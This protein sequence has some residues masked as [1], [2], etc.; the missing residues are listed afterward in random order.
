MKCFNHPESDA[1]GICKSCQKGICH[2]CAID[3]GKGIACKGQCE[4]DVT[5]VNEALARNMELGSL[6]RNIMQGFPNN[7]MI[8][9]FFFMLMGL[10][11]SAWG[12]FS[13]R[14]SGF[15]VVLGVGFVLY[16]VIQLS[17]ALRLQRRY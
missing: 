17:R 15:I 6:N 9:S 10:V 11:F 1:V 4:S 7:L 16:G 5:A 14:P 3:L 8:A 12:V 2:E 13:A